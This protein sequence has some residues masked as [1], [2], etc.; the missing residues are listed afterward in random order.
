MPPEYD[1]FEEGDTPSTPWVDPKEP[2]RARRAIDTSFIRD[3]EPTPEPEIQPDL[4][5]SVEQSFSSASPTDES[6]LSF[7]SSF[8]VPSLPVPTST[9]KEEEPLENL[10]AAP[11][12]RLPSGTM[13][14]QQPLGVLQSPTPSTTVISNNGFQPIHDSTHLSGLQS[15]APSSIANST[16]V[17]Q[18]NQHGSSTDTLAAQQAV[19]TIDGDDDDDDFMIITA[20]RASPAAQL[21]WSKSTYHQSSDG[22]VS[23][24]SESKDN[25]QTPVAPPT[26]TVP[27]TPVAPPKKVAKQPVDYS[28]MI[29]ASRALLKN[30]HNKNNGNQIGSI[31]GGRSRTPNPH[32]NEAESSRA[33]AARGFVIDSPRPNPF[34][35][36]PSQ[37]DAAMR[38]V[39]EDHAWMHD[40]SGS[41]DEF[42]TLKTL[43][44]S[45]SK[46]GKA[47]KL[48]ETEKMELYKLEKTLEQ[49]ARLRT[50]AMQRVTAGN[51][52][53]EDED[54]LFVQESREDIARRHRRNRPPRNI[55]SE[56]DEMADEGEGDGDGDGDEDGDDGTMMKMLQQELNGHGL[57]GPGDGEPKLNKNGKPRKKRAKAA[58]NAREVFEREEESRRQ[59][60]R[61]K[62][63]KKKGR[64]GNA[65]N[66]RRKPSAAAKGEGKA[67]SKKP[68]KGKKGTVKNGESLL[69]SGNFNRYSGT[70]DI[71]QMM[72]EDLMTNDPISDRLQNPIFNVEPEA[73]MPG[74]HSKDS[75]FAMLFANI[76][77]GDGSKDNVKSVKNDKKALREASRSFGYAHVKAQDGKWLIKG[78]KSTLYHHQLLG[79]QWMVKRELS[80]QQPHGGLLADSMG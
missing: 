60:E 21:K 38:D 78:M 75:Q 68:A 70:D 47:G 77:S 33:G 34:R 1:P 57:D 31:F 6:Q 14:R 3:H 48:T 42:E 28:K 20:D 22:V 52:E 71:G 11:P 8:N 65:S 46:K 15:P 10:Y 80:S 69:R 2:P 44:S 62:A 63:Q 27:S 45:L 53:D 29:A 36:D 32:Q 17:I 55:E 18:N 13:N 25:N 4:M 50:A 67:A 7:A 19:L 56:D 26:L 74:Q 66:S 39:D 59:K 76:P 61:S 73:P 5:Q 41:D 16:K 64:G 51:D 37:V 40:D 79:A 35:D 58:R 54:T 12:T 30:I 43:H 49:K 9:I 24:K 23:V 72:L